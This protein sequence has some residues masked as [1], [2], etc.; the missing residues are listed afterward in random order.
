MAS[1][2]GTLRARLTLDAKPFE[3]G[4]TGA[5][6]RMATFAKGMARNVAIAGAA[7]AAASVAATAAL[8]K[9]SLA[10][11]DQ[12]AKVARSID[13]SITGLRALQLAGNDAGVSTGDLNSSMQKLGARLV[14]AKVKGG[15]AGDALKR[16]GL[17]ADVLLA[18]DAD[19]RLAAIADRMNQLGLSSS[20]AAQFLKEL[21]VESKE[22]ALLL[23]GGGDAIRA[24]RQEVE[25]LGLGLSEIDAS[26]VEAANDAMSRIRLVTEALGNRLAVALAPALKAMSEGFTASMRSGGLLRTVVDVVAWRIEALVSLTG[27]LVT[28]LA[29]AG[30]AVLDFVSGIY[31]SIGALLNLGETVSATTGFIGGFI[32]GIRSSI[33]FL[34]DLIRTTGSFGEAMAALA[35]L[36][37][38]VW[39]RIGDGISYISNSM[40]AGAAKMSS[41]FLFNLGRMASK[42]VSFTQTVA[43]GLN[44][45]FRTNTFSGASALITQ[46]LTMG[47]REAEA[48]ASAAGARANAAAENFKAP[49]K[50]LAAL[51]AIIAKSG[52]DAAKSLDEGTDAADEFGDAL[53]SGAGGKGSAAVQKVKSDIDDL[54]SSGSEMKSTFGAAFSSLVSGAKS[55]RDVIKDL[56]SKLAEMLA[57]RAFDSLWDGF[58]GAKSSKSAS[59]GGFVSRLFAGFFDGGG[60]IPSGK[61][62]IAGEYGPEFVRGPAVVT[63]RMD[64]ARALQGGG[65]GVA[66]I[67]VR[68]EPG[69]IVEIARNEAGA[70]I[71]R[72]SSGIVN[73]S[74]GA[75]QASFRKTKSGWSP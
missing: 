5:R 61:F 55:L 13:G 54:N 12:Q 8:T 73:Q 28:I 59:G 10:F 43:E 46:E 14:K 56:L 37:G 62:G 19:A 47:Y 60:K 58:A 48:A 20:Q 49:L 42:F 45:L 32:G 33:A 1:S 21:G 72:A 70:M 39:G 3:R 7:M 65:G 24:A 44:G 63:S 69:T 4:L 11:V 27:D 53:D 40:E 22:M 6:S 18:M 71:R 30:R 74:V 35:P 16:L 36:A 15:A 17:D 52:K 66:E 51:Q 38:E 64:T 34:A 26:K 50:S 23:I 29:S 57:N 25:D 68:N 67:I 41:F 75:A 9:Q 2:V 31:S